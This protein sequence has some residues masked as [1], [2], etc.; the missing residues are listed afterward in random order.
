MPARSKT[1]TRTKFPVRQMANEDDPDRDPL[2][3]VVLHD[4]VSQAGNPQ[5]KGIP[6]DFGLS[7]T[8]QPRPDKSLCDDVGIFDHATAERLPKCG[9]RKGPTRRNERSGFQGSFGRSRMMANRWTQDWKTQ[10]AGRV[11]AAP[12]RKATRS[13]MKC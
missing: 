8:T 2:K 4:S 9:A 1:S 7:P 10:A 11:T 3:L 13:G 5:H 12:C 6:G